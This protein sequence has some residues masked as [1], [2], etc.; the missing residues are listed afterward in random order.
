MNIS[1][2]DDPFDLNRFQEAQENVYGTA[3]SE[4]KNGRKLSHWMWFVFP[5][6]EG[7][8]N[9]STAKRYAIKSMEEAKAYLN[10]PILG[11]RLIECTK[12]LLNIKG[13]SASDIFGHPD[14]LKFC[15]SMTL[16]EYVASKNS[17]FSEA[18]DQYFGG[19]KDAKTLALID[20]TW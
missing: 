18:L 12:T 7:L 14:D 9:S 3:L 10:H 19:Q 20:S 1:D 2:N 4:L 5:Q 15:S 16:F 17:L 6:I 8:G 11:S 13:L